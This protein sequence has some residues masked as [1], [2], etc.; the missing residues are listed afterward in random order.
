MNV[1]AFSVPSGVV[2]AQKF[3]SNH[4]A[5][6]VVDESTRIKTPGAK[7]T[8]NIIKVGKSAVSR[9]ILSGLPITQGPLDYFAQF[10]FLDP[11][12]LGFGSMYAF[13]NRYAL[14]GGYLGKEVMGYANLDELIA[15]VDPHSFRVEREECMDL[16]PKTYTKRFTHL[17]V[18]QKQLYDSMARDL[19]AEFAGGE[20]HATIVLTQLLRLQQITGGFLPIPED[21]GSYQGRVDAIPGTNAK[22]QALMEVL[23]EAPGKVIIWA[24]FR[25]ELG[26]IANHILKEFGEGSGVLFHGGVSQADRKVALLSFQDPNSPIKYFIANAQ[27]G[28][29]GL[30]LTEA[31]TVVYFSNSF[32]LEERLQ[33]EDRC[34]RGGLKHPVTYV[35]LVAKDTLDTKVLDALRTKKNMATLITGDRIAEWI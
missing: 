17:G 32:S 23:E 12:I 25:A 29:L 35:D 18:V 9:R 10:Q 30:T 20:V 33:S 6:M 5:L 2:V 24:R 15:L 4:A 3:L 19:V 11:N 27:T 14:L 34:H 13:R 1:D 28:G 22:I 8:K 21:D 7:R 26:L 31:Q 16:P